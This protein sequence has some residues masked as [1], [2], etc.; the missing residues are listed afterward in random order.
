MDKL[1]NPLFGFIWFE[2]GFI[3]NFYNFKPLDKDSTDKYDI[4]SKLVN[5]TFNNIAGEIQL[6]RGF[7]FED[8]DKKIS[9]DDITKLIVNLYLKKI[10]NKITLV[11]HLDKIVFKLVYALAMAQ[12]NM[13]I[14]RDIKPQNILINADYDVA[15]ADWGISIATIFGNI[16][17]DT[18]TIQ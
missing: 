8:P 5:K 4:I 14:H 6:T 11:E 7:I 18:K 1:L 17:N 3:N 13:I 2:F 15:V 16:S 10:L 12:D 9:I